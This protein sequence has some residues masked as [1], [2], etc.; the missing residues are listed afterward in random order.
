MLKKTL[1]ILLFLVNLIFADTLKYF[2]QRTQIY[3]LRNRGWECGYGVKLVGSFANIRQVP[4]KILGVVANVSPIPYGQR[5]HYRIWILRDSLGFPQ[6]SNSI[7]EKDTFFTIYRDTLY[8]L[9]LPEVVCYDTILYLF[10]LSKDTAMSVWAL[11]SF[12][13]AGVEDAYWKYD[14]LGFRCLGLIQGDL[15]LGLLVEFL[16]PGI[17]EKKERK[18]LKYYFDILGRRRYKK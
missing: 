1:I 10:F 6:R 18:F 5:R 16:A 2:K 13:N 15:E 4:F 8:F 17:K 7:L 9:A 12:M 14:S 3:G 11:D